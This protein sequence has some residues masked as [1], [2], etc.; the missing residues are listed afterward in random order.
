MHIRRIYS[1][2]L[3]DLVLSIRV[4]Q[5]YFLQLYRTLKTNLEDNG[6]ISE[7]QG[8]R[9]IKTFFCSPGWL[10]FDLM[11]VLNLKIPNNHLYVQYGFLTTH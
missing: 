7:G 9:L 11:F 3:C 6:K 5:A 1:F 4:I 8:K 10:R 2:H